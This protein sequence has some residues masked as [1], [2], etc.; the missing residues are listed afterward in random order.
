MADL[1][2]FIENNTAL[3]NDLKLH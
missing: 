3:I 2:D 1:F